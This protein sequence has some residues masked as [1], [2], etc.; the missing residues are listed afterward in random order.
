M[1]RDGKDA[2]DAE[3]REHS[4]GAAERDR[5][6]AQGTPEV[7]SADWTTCWPDWRYDNEAV[8]PE[9]MLLWMI[10]G[11]AATL[12]LGETTYPLRPDECYLMRLWG[13]CHGRHDPE[14]PLRVDWILFRLLDGAG[15]PIDLASRA[16]T[17]ALAP[18]AERRLP[19]DARPMRMLVDRT[20]AHHKDRS[21][22]RAAVRHWLR[23]VLLEIDAQD[24]RLAERPALPP[25]QVKLL[26]L[27]ERIRR[28]PERPW[29]VEAMA[30]ALHYS[31]DHF[32]RLFKAVVGIAPRAF[33][34][35]RRLERAK[36]LLRMSSTPVGVIAAMLGYADLYHFSRQFK[37]KTGLSPTAYRQS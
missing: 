6:W 36:T 3:D 23:A 5:L 34:V 29:R 2:E 28:A 24:R 11:G 35:E 22:P 4:A 37:A 33:V 19:M 14:D 31:P 1:A 9:Q 12:T 21:Q 25:E 13:A 27:C 30:E 15:R 18:P 10:H 20:I 7:I 32:T 8:K 17:G 26:E 16:A